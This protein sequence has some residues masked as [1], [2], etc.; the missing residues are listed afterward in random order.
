MTNHP[1]IKR[2]YYGDFGGQFIP[3][4]LRRN[5]EEL[6]KAFNEAW[7]DEAFRE[8][9]LELM[10]DFVGRPT[11]LQKA[12]RWSERCGV[13]IWFKREDLAHTCLLYTSPSPRD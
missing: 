1:I 3:E 10:H 13:E 2:G 12:V 6:E 7:A 11:P 4:M 9:Y 8:E 5:F